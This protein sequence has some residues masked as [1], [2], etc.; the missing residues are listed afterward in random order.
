MNTKSIVNG[1]SPESFF[2]PNIS[3]SKQ[4]YNFP[5][6]EPL[7][8]TNTQLLKHESPPI[9]TRPALYF[10]ISV[11]YCL[12]FNLALFCNF[13]ELIL[14][15]DNNGCAKFVLY[16]CYKHKSCNEFPV[17]GWRSTTTF[18]I[19]IIWNVFVKKIGP[20]QPLIFFIFVFSTLNMFITLVLP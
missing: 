16:L 5:I 3:P 18:C 9:T 19:E 6:Y 15:A 14:L 1:T 11:K 10:V 2:L 13:I 12:Q 20:P 4:Q 8:N 7:P 17:Q